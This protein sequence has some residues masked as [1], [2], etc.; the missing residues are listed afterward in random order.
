MNYFCWGYFMH[1]AVIGSGISGLSA[2]WLLS[3]R[4][5]VVL[6]EKD[7]RLGGHANTQLFEIDGA[8]LAADTGFLVYN[9]LNYPNLSALF[10]YLDIDTKASDMSFAASLDGGGFEYS[11]SS[12]GGMMAQKSNLL[13]RRFWTMFR[14][15][16]RFYRDAPR[17]VADPATANLSLG[18]FLEREN[19]STSF[20]DDH[21]LPMG[22]A[23]WSMSRRGMLDFPLA[24]FVRFCANHGLLKLSGRPLWRTVVGGSMH[25]VERLADAISGE[26]R[27]NTG[28][29]RINRTARGVHITDRQ[30]N[31]EE[32][33]AVVVATHA[34]QALKLLGDASYHERKLLGDI[35]YQR[36]I[37]I[38][39]TDETLMPKRR[40]CWASWNYIQSGD[41]EEVVC[42][43]YWLNK[44]Q[45]L[46][47]D[48]NVFVTLNP[49]EPPR[50]G[51]IIRSFLYDHPVYDE[52]A[53]A[54]QNQL[55]RL[56]GQNR[57]WFCGAHFGYGFHEDGLQAG[58]AVAEALGDVRRPWACDNESDRINMGPP[59]DR[60]APLEAA[61]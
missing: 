36:N 40:K 44:L 1:V 61:E 51:T 49:T 16:L 47:T 19:Y 59:A 29:A 7:D 58:L 12:L 37:A 6:Y 3:K 15:I 32:F 2:A 10:R 60:Q 25:Y 42:V 43:T 11:G 54:A 50:D 46:D 27:L 17:A 39:H 41:E 53:V 22:A 45:H 35:G 23:I 38:L 13:R 48:K 4:H 34:D 14:D 21:L 30:G 57:T 52:A 56:Q 18:D 20:R 28:V 8:E 5:R 33:D 9:D 24:V 31:A 26:V 55:W